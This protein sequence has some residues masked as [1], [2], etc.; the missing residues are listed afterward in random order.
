MPDMPDDRTVPEKAID[1]IKEVLERHDCAG[2][3]VVAS[4]DQV[5]FVRKIDPTWSC[6]WMEPVPGDTDGKVTV[7]IR[8]KLEEYG[9]DKERQKAEIEATTGMFIAFMGWAEGTREQMLQI[10]T[11]LGRHYPEILHSEHWRRGKW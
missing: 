10:T 2:L 9:G 7:R 6:A 8:S 4:K 11:M 5:A 1:E 3:V